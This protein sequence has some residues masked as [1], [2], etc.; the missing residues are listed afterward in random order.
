LINQSKYYYVLPTNYGV[1]YKLCRLQN[2]KLIRLLN[3]SKINSQTSRE[4]IHIL[5]RGNRPERDDTKSKNTT[6]FLN[7]RLAQLENISLKALQD[8]RSDL[9]SLLSKYKSKIKLEIKDSK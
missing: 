3:S 7:V 6:R 4:Q 2:E 8:F 5:S 9:E 1:L